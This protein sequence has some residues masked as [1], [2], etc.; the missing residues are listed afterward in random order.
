MR[1]HPGE[2]KPVWPASISPGDGRDPSHYQNFAVTDD[3][4]IFFFGRAE[5]LPSYAGATSVTVPRND[6]PPLQ[7]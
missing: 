1:A 3:A 7:L 2:P 5:L 4:V 6:I